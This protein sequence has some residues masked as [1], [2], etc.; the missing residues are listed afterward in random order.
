MSKV[1]QNTEKGALFNKFNI[2]NFIR[3]YFRNLMKKKE[4]EKCEYK[5]CSVFIKN[6]SSYRIF[7][8]F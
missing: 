1:K 8:K 5:Q 7:Y 4:G 6:V 2:N 3:L